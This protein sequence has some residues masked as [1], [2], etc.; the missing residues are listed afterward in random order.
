M[1]TT[2]KAI[3]A[4]VALAAAA[5][6]ALAGTEPYFIPLTQSSAVASPNHINELNSPWQTP[7]GISYKNLTS[8]QE[9]EADVTQSIQRVPGVG[10]STSMFD[11]LAMDPTGQYVFIPHETP[12]GAGV[13]RYSIADDT[14]TLVFAGDQQGAGADGARG[15]AD[16]QWDNDFGAF[17]PARWTPWGTVILA[18]EWS[19]LGRVVEVMDPMSSPN[20]PIAGGSE[21]VEGQDWRVLEGIASV[22]HE[23]INFSVKAPKE[24]VYFIDEDRSGSIYKLVLANSNDL[25]AGGQ[26]FVLVGD[27]FSGD[28]V[29]NWNAGPNSD[30]A[31]QASRFGSARWVPITGPNGEK[32]EGITSP[33]GPSVLNCGAVSPADFCRDEDIR[34]GRVAADDAGG[35]P[36][37]RPEDMTIGINR[38]GQETLYVTTTS[39]HAVI[40]I[41]TNPRSSKAVVRQF[42]SRNTPRN[43]GF[44]PT[45]GTLSSPDNLATDSLGNVYI[46]E[47]K[48]NGDDVG[49]DIW[50]ARDTDNDG[51][52]ESIDHFLSLQVDGAEATGMIFNPTHPS[53]FVVAV[54]HPDSVDIENV[55]L[56]CAAEAPHT[57]QGDAIWQFEVMPFKAPGF[58]GA[59]EGLKQKWT[60]ATA[61]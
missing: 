59:A 61:P 34:P 11:M 7:A 41:A 16:D 20:D 24:V 42:A 39:E 57:C 50:F 37:G 55:D 21:L 46:I 51:V 45:T 47:D 29:E 5:Q 30:P 48:P 9:V 38:Y 8:M 18:E 44:Q 49:G 32:L 4:G 15:N 52:A 13:T 53:Q 10:T 3:A 60:R 28:V 26:T 54:Q 58:P 35:L 25:A 1:K 23:G 14:S 12:I 2:I 22:S 27:N 36:F 43:L 56:S 6:P 17:D 31:V 19:G 40:S 33:F